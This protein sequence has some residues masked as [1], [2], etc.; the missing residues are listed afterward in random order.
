MAAYESSID[1][2]QPEENGRGAA[3]LGRRRGAWKGP[4]EIAA[5][6]I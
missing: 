6:G 2:R 3:D 1:Q 5:M 4:V